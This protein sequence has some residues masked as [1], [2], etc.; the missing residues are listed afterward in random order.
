MANLG[1]DLRGRIQAGPEPGRAVARIT[2]LG[3]GQALRQLFAEPARDQGVPEQ[4]VHAVIEI[5]RDWQPRVDG[6]VLVESASRPT[7][8]TDLAAGLSRFL[9]KPVVG[10]WAIA[11]PSVE[12][13]RGA[14]NSAQRVAA[15]DRRFRLEADVPAGP[16]LLVDDQVVTGWTLTLAAKA[17]REA[18]ASAVLP[19]VLATRA[20]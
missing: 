1:L 7:L 13:G 4:L 10:R 9:K 14:M 20:G 2:D 6:I 3:H 19:L 5:L 11:D 17:L 16:V 15:V 12:P 8:T 18:G